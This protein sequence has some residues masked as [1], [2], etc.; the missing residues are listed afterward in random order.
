[1][2][3]V[4]SQGIAPKATS[5]TSQEGTKMESTN[6]P[7]WVEFILA[8]MDKRFDAQDAKLEK[9]LTRDAFREEQTRVNDLIRDLQKDTAKNTSDINAEATARMNGEVAR[10]ARER[11]ETQRSQ[12]TE[13]QTRWQ[14]FV[15]PATAVA[16]YLVPWILSGGMT[17]Q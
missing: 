3:G 12:A 7:P 10:T 13:R 1:M 17:Q 14:W 4:V 6:I 9:F 16:G 2:S 8:Q 5:G 15:I 11:D